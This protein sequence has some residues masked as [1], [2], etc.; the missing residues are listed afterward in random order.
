MRSKGIDSNCFIISTL[1]QCF[2]DMGKP[3]EAVQLFNEFKSDIFLDNVTYNMA[4]G[5]LCKLGRVEVA[6]ELL[7]EM[8]GKGMVLDIVHYTTLINGYCLQG[9]ICSALKVLEQIKERGLQLDIVTY[10]VLAHGYSRTGLVREAHELLRCMDAWGVKPDVVTHNKIIEGLCISGR[11]EEAEVFFSGLQEK[12]AANKAAMFEGYCQANHSRK[13]FKL[14]KELSEAEKKSVKKNSFFKLVAALCKAG[15]MRN[16]KWLFDRSV[17]KGLTPDVVTYTL[18]IDGYFNANRVQEGLFLF[19]DMKKRGVEPDVVTYTC[20]LMVFQRLCKLGNIEKAEDLLRELIQSGLQP[21]VVTYTSLIAGC[22]KSGSFLQIHGNAGVLQASL[23]VDVVA[24][25]GSELHKAIPEH[26]SIQI[27]TTVQWPRVIQGWPKI[28]HPLMTVIKRIYQF[29]MLLWFLFIKVPAPDVFLVQ[30]PPSVP[31]GTAVTWVSWIR[32]S[33]FI[34]DWHNF[35]YT[36]LAS[37]LGRNVF[38]IKD[39]NLNMAFHRRTSDEDFGILLEAVCMNDRRV[40]AILNEDDSTDKEV[41][42]TEKDLYL[43]LL[44]V[45]TGKGPDK[46]KYEQK[47]RKLNLNQGS[48]LIGAYSLLYLCYLP[49]VL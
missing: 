22:C 5:A 25:G 40:A 26:K 4:V 36:L 3:D 21:D 48:N 49:E 37:S 1:I 42:W 14:F 7:E 38:L 18:M 12:S 44:F 33:A 9:D 32:R 30:N 47:I 43:R 29:I 24:Y 6:A 31:T 15:D 17:E 34:V 10:N 28:L 39:T 11:V 23:E 13:A 19:N 35:G 8:K 2:C 46:E 45:I 20:Y 16:A 27:H 41:L